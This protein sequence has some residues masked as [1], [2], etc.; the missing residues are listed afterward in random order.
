MKDERLSPQEMAWMMQEAKENHEDVDWMLYLHQR[1]DELFDE[2][3]YSEYKFGG[4]IRRNT[5][6][7]YR[8]VLLSTMLAAAERA[9]DTVK[10]KN[11]EK[12]VEKKPLQGLDV[13]EVGFGG[14]VEA[15]DRPHYLE[16]AQL[17]AKTWGLEHG[18]ESVEMAKRNCESARDKFKGLNGEILLDPSQ[19]RQGGMENLPKIFPYQKF[20]VVCSSTVFAHNPLA[21]TPE[22][23]FDE[24]YKDA[25]AK[26][27]MAK[28]AAVL[29]PGGL[30]IHNNMDDFHFPKPEAIEAMGYKILALNRRI[31][32]AAPL[33]EYYSV[34]M[35]K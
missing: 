33:V 22:H 7:Y 29:K 3:K 32:E 1:A 23:I 19:M 35:K 13:L 16:I 10:V 11:V 27:W 17:G 15:E 20:D 9:Y 21:G 12:A 24:G 34:F 8:L 4:N 31:E 6:W 30:A 18:K 26:D 28:I 2:S 5:Y 14:E 25:K